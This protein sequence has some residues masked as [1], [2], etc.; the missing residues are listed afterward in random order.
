DRPRRP[1]GADGAVEPGEDAGLHFG[2]AEPGS[3]LAV[4]DAP[5]A[6]ERKLGPA[7]KAVAVGGGDDRHRQALDAVAPSELARGDVLD[8]VLDLVLG[9]EAFELA[10]VGAGDEARVLAAHDHEALELAGLGA[11]DRLDDLAE[12]LGGPA[13]ERV[14]ALALAVDDRPGDALEVDRE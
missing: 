5:G 11:L 8:P 14:H 4:G 7:A 6:G 12:L 2:K 10:D 1:D 13:A 9:V 3:L